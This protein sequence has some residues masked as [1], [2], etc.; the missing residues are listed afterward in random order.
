MNKSKVDETGKV[1]NNKFILFDILV[2]DSNHLVGL[3]FQDRINLIS[4]IYGTRDSD[5]DYLYVIS[6][7]VFRV[8]SFE[9]NFENLFKNITVGDAVEGLVLKRKSAKLEN[10]LTENNN[11]KSQIKCRVQTKNYKF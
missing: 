3:T 2:K 6:E 9:H 4:E 5:K 7:N 10:G 11:T 1:F 8:K